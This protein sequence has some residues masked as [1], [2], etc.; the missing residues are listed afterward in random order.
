MPAVAEHSVVHPVGRE[1]ADS[2]H[3]DVVDKEHDNCE[4][5]K[6]EPAV[7]DDLIDLVGGRKLTDILLFVAGFYDRC[8]ID[9]SLIRDDGLCVVIH[10]FLNL[11]NVALDVLKGCLVEV[12]L[13][14]H[15]VV[16]LKDFN[17]VPSLLLL[18]QAVDGSFFDVGESVLDGAFKGVHR[19]SLGALC[20]LDSSL[21]SVHDSVTFKGGNLDYLAAELAGELIDVYF[22]AVLL[23]DVHHVDG[24]NNGDAELGQLG[25]EIEVSFE[26]RTVDYVKYS[27][28]ALIDKIVSRDNFLKGIGRE[29]VDTGKV[30]DDNAVMLFEFSFFFL[31]RN[32]RPVTDELVR[33]GESVEQCGFT[34]VGVTRK[35]NA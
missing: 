28:R 33:T 27:V 17:G 13:C 11:F 30:G 3:G 10:L 5:R 19:N 32:A 26:V 16:A 35:S 23:D 34:A 31:N 4:Y 9:I 2:D 8:D 20:S 22:V 1:R 15:L 12:E 14:K 21:G 25:G 6:S 7:C 29:R 18:W 24:D